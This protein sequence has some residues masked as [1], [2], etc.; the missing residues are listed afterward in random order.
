MPN[1]GNCG[2]IYETVIIASMSESCNVRV[3]LHN[4]ASTLCTKASIQVCTASAN[5]M[6]LEIYPYFSDADDYVQILKNPSEDSILDG[7]LRVTDEAGLGAVI[8]L[9]GMEKYLTFDSR[10]KL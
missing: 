4:C 8:D 10:Q 1:V 5:A 9:P 6:P 3:S 7:K 2:G